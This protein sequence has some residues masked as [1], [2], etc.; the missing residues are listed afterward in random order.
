[1]FVKV[2]EFD[3]AQEEKKTGPEKEIEK[4]QESVFV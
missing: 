2:V 1:M 4:I 3:K